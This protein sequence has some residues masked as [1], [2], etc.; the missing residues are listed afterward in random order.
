MGV[1]EEGGVC[2]PGW[3]MVQQASV[4]LCHL[5]LRLRSQQHAKSMPYLCLFPPFCLFRFL[6]PSHPPPPHQQTRSIRPT[7]TPACEPLPPQY[8][9]CIE[10]QT[11]T[12]SSFITCPIW[13]CCTD[14]SFESQDLLAV[15]DA[16]GPKWACRTYSP[17]NEIA[18][19][20]KLCGNGQ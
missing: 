12:T 18:C 15:C 16:N 20:M 5:Q 14:G 10:W 4:Q 6:P 9:D 11:N 3:Q 19:D 13:Q 1:C 2:Q 17:F 7:P 8:T